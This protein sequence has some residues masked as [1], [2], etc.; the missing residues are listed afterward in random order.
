MEEIRFK[1]G[2]NWKNFNR[3]VNDE[4]ILEAKNSLCDF[5]GIQDLNRKSFLDIGSGSGLFSL[6][7]RNLGAS[8][9]S[10]DYDIESVNCTEALKNRYF[11]DTTLWKIE[12][13]SIL[14]PNYL[15]TLGQF[16]ICYAWGV[17]HHTGSL[18]QA[19]YN[20]HLLV[21]KEGLLFIGIYND[22]GFISKI[23]KFIK[24]AY[25]HN[26]ISRMI[27]I[28]LFFSIFFMTGLIVDI[29]KLQNP[30]IRY[31][32]HKKYRGMS[33]IHDW[34]DWLG[35]YPYEPADP[36]EIISFFE[37]LN[38]KLLNFKATEHGFGNNQFLFQKLG[39]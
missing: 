37:K 10:F 21:K 19:I 2:K 5:L 23:W 12:Q 25:C 34:Y 36:K 20:T 15:K 7:A 39:T 4:R 35:G 17:L 18:W 24:K 32:A 14:D 11:P 6:T 31:K 1:F 22:Q 29:C 28:C 16:D 13:G 8:V 3:V 26:K 38:Y 33:L 9:H 30:I 27:L